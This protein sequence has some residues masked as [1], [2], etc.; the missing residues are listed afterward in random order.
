MSR[1]NVRNQELRIDA[2]RAV[3][4]ALP[5]RRNDGVFAD[6]QRAPRRIRIARF[7]VG[8]RLYL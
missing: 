2:E 4:G 3:L 1:R 8:N 6:P 7:R 5:G